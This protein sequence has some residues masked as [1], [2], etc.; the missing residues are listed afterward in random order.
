MMKIYDKGLCEFFFIITALG[1]E[2]YKTKD[3][4]YT[5]IRNIKV[6]KLISMLSLQ[7]SNSFFFENFNLYSMSRHY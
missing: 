1:A 7:E 4:H 6:Y 3:A 2:K 5:G